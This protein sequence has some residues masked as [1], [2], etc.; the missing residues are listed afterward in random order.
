MTITINVSAKRTLD[1]F[2]DY[3][4]ILL[5]SSLGHAIIFMSLE[6]YYGL[7]AQLLTQ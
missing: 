3:W 7:L 5:P 1:I 2:V 6:N 4:Q